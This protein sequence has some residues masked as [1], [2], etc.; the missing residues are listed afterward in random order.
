MVLSLEFV[1]FAE[2]DD[3]FLQPS[4]PKVVDDVRNCIVVSGFA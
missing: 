4:L 2:V 3:V 1:L